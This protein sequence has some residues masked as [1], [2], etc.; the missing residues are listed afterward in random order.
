MAETYDS[1]DLGAPGSPCGWRPAG[2]L[3]RRHESCDQHER[4]DP[5]ICL[6]WSFDKLISVGLIHLWLLTSG[7]GTADL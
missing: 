1:V 3:C 7:P 5:F 4:H 6:E 2:E